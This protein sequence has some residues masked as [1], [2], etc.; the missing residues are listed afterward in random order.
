[1]MD[2]TV[3]I[4]MVGCWEISQDDLMVYMREILTAVLWAQG[5]VDR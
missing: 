2:C 4:L 3:A 5:M 1:M